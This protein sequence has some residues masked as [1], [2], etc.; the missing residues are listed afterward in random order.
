MGAGSVVE[1]RVWCLGS[2][3]GTGRSSASLP[4][5]RHLGQHAINCS[6]R[7]SAPGSKRR[8]VEGRLMGSLWRCRKHLSTEYQH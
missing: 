7:T 6:L 4:Y 1:R 3:M 5:T 8:G 2:L